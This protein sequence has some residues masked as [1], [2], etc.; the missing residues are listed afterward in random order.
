MKNLRKQI[1]TLAEA[2]NGIKLP[3]GFVKP[4]EWG[5]MDADDK[6]DYLEKWNELQNYLKGGW[7]NGG[8]TIPQLISQLQQAYSKYGDIRV[9][10]WDEDD[11]KFKLVDTIK[12]T[13]VDNFLLIHG[14][15]VDIGSDEDYF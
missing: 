4:R 13:K 9:C 3:A 10:V 12:Y 11:E 7:K 6:E 1:L 2:E 15:D 14:D 5:N 8:L